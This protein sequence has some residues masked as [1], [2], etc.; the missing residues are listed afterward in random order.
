ME[1]TG[2]LLFPST[3]EIFPSETTQ[4]D[5]DPQDTSWKIILE[6]VKVSVTDLLNHKES[7]K[8]F[9]QCRVSHYKL[10]ISAQ[11]KDPSQYFNVADPSEFVKALEFVTETC[12][13]GQPKLHVFKTLPPDPFT[14][15]ITILIGTM[16]EADNIQGE[17]SLINN[18]ESSSST[19]D[20]MQEPRFPSTERLSGV[21]FD[22]PITYQMHYW[23]APKNTNATLSTLFHTNMPALCRSRIEV[24][25]SKI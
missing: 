23:F 9:S 19:W 4:P 13:L 22:L 10:L 8:Y 14:I 15:A 6:K 18:S 17:I 16:H 12:E 3:S 25:K 24:L 11:S 21:I 7:P 2:R 1:Q 20:E 5:Q